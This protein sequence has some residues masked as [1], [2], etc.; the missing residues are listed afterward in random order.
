ME[1]NGKQ[2]HSNSDIGKRITEGVK[3]KQKSSNDKQ[4]GLYSNRKRKRKS[5]DRDVENKRL[6]GSPELIAKVSAKNCVDSLSQNNERLGTLQPK[7]AIVKATVK[8]Q[9]M[10]VLLAIDYDLEN[11]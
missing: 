1:E 6:K 5:I 10:F 7:I 8:D 3:Q 11:R 9:I 2:Y 4:L